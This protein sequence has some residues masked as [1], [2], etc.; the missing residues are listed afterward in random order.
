MNHGVESGYDAPSPIIVT[1]W[2]VACPTRLLVWARLQVR[3]SGVAEVFDCDG[4]LLIYDGEDSARAALMDAEFRALDGLDDDDVE[5]WGVLLED[6][7]PPEGENDDDLV[8]QMQQTLEPP[9]E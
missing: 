7:I 9:S 8:P 1:A 2:W 4:Q 5:G 6:I 3:A